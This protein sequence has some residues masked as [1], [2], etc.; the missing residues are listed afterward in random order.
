VDR[1]PGRVLVGADPEKA[2]FFRPAL[3][4]DKRGVA[5]AERTEGPGPIRRFA[6]SRQLSP[7]FR[8]KDFR[9]GPDEPGDPAHEIVHGPGSIRHLRQGILPS[10]GRHRIHEVREGRL[11][12]SHEG[13][14]LFRRKDLLSFPDD[15][16][17]GNQRLEYAGP[18]R[19]GSDPGRF[20]QGFLRL[21]ILDELVDVAEINPR[22][23]LII[24]SLCRARRVSVTS[25]LIP[26]FITRQRNIEGID[27][28][29]FL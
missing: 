19:F 22:K 14:S 13:P 8:E 9:M 26:R 5:P 16:F 23:R 24:F 4:P 3:Q 29:F 17:P 2:S 12:K 28:L 10:G 27:K 20:L 21:G 1:R 11:Q 18:G 6:P 15:V 7:T 25:S